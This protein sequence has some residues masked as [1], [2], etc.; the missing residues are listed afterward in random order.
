[1]TKGK[2]LESI[3]SSV[4]MNIKTDFG[5]KKIFGNKV[6]LTAFLIQAS[7]QMH[8]AERILFYMGYPVISQAPKGSVTLTDSGGK[9]IKVP[10]DYS[11]SGVYMICIL[12]NIM[13]PEKEAADIVIEQMKIVRQKADRLFTGKWEVK[14]IE[15]PK[16][17]KTEDELET[18]ADKWLYFLK[19]MK[20][21]PGRP[22][23]LNDKIFSEL[24]ENAKIINLTGE[25]MKAYSKS[26]LEYDDVISSINYRE[27]DSLVFHR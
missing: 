5:F 8:F 7:S 10:W 15:L 6:L 16:F 20:K 23:K 3:G 13:F 19:H 25:D 27:Y 18:T 12:N 2:V 1:M 9:E 4:F 24:Y 21:L 26:V 11:L 22:E 17:S 14:T